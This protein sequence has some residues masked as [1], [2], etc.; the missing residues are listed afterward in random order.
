M[1]DLLER[2]E[3]Q[4]SFTALAH[5]KYFLTTVR[6]MRL[7]LFFA[8]RLT[9]GLYTTLRRRVL[10]CK[11]QA[12]ERLVT[13]QL[14]IGLMDPGVRVLHASK[15]GSGTDSRIVSLFDCRT[16]DLLG[17]TTWRDV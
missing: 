9:I 15:E 5:C 12:M 3:S 2:I 4:E 16:L 11:L 8:F 7:F 13:L 14:G 1:Y 17:P 10:R 6:Q